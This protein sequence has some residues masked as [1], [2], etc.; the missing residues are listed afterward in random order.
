MENNK[1]SL[2]KHA[3]ING[4]IVGLAMIIYSVIL[5]IL[6]M[7][8]NQ[9]A[10]WGSYIILIIGIVITTKS[11]RDK[12]NNGFLTYGKGFTYGLVISIV[13]SVLV[14]IYSFLY[15]KMIDPD[16]IQRALIMAEET[17]IERGLPDE[18]IEQAMNITKRMMTPL[19]MTLTSLLWTAIVGIVASL[20]IAAIFKKEQTVSENSVNEGEIKTEE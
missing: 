4:L 12:A 16:A 9:T 5:Y 6:G 20:I 8:E 1:T 18:Q 19:F 13:A 17:M 15:L 2:G 7:T 14:A 11:F 10:E 3:F